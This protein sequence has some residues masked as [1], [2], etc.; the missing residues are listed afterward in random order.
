MRKYPLR[1]W[2]S[3]ISEGNSLRAGGAVFR[4]LCHRNGEKSAPRRNAGR[5]Q[6][7]EPFTSKKKPT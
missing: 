1:P 7:A 2:R 6:D 5:L 4:E 3:R